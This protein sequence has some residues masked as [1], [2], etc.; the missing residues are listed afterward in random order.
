LYL[1]TCEEPLKGKGK[2]KR[3]RKVHPGTGHEA[4]EAEQRYISALSLTSALDGVVGQ[5][6]A[7]ANLPR[8]GD[9]VLILQE[10][11]WAPRQVWTGTEK[12][13]ST[14]IRYADRPA[15]SESLNQL[16]YPSRKTAQTPLCNLIF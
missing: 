2:R 11:E 1:I 12:L 3:K 16:R 7:P 9:T 6:N 5:R 10:A 13:V 14:G 15:R 8:E 4:P